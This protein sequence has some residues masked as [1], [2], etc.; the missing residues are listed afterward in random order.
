MFKK[1]FF[2][3]VICLFIK[4]N[5]QD[6]TVSPYSY[7]G[8]GTFNPANT[9]ENNAMGGL[10]IYGD[11]IHVNLQNPASYGLLKLTTYTVGVSHRRMALTSDTQEKS[12]ALTAIDYLS[13]AMPIAENIGIGFGI[14]PVTSMGYI[15]NSSAENANGETIT[16]VFSGDGGLSKIYFSLG[17]APIKNFT[18]GA[19]AFANFGTVNKERVQSLSS[20]LF[21]T[22][23]RRTSRM[24]GFNFQMAANY[25][26]NIIDKLTLYTSF[27]HTTGLDLKA[28]NTQQVGS[29]SLV[30][31]SE[32]E[33]S[34]LDLEAANLKN[35]TVKIP[36][37]TTLGL[38]I[39]ENKK[40]LLGASYTIQEMGSF[41]S[42]FLSQ[43]NVAY[44][45]ASTLRVGGYYV[46]DYA[47]FASFFK[48]ATYRFG[49]RLVNTGMQVNNQAIKD[50][51][52]NIGVGLPM[53][54]TFSN[55]NIGIEMGALGTSKA[56]LIKE[57][58][59]SLR[60]GLSLN[61]RWFLKRKIN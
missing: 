10:S 46:P 35:N 15:L 23:D 56:G 55:L 59:L 6:G 30:N 26:P 40:W 52:T 14:T 49:I 17:A 36:S 42:T 41:S 45:E 19:S 25:T 39:G 4:T 32:L 60:V 51:G 38:G 34:D 48:R 21:G 37:V 61:D 13:V 5:A 31:G 58:Y 11:S 1:L 54:G 8:L 43:S 29:L 50:F 33:V 27:V 12:T 18:V 7:F 20:V 22:I 24:N 3:L 53:G 47:P 16:N 57:N 2:T 28:S 9:V 44:S